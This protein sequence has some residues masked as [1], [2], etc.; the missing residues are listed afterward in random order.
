MMITR[1]RV[2][3]LISVEPEDVDAMV[4][5]RRMPRPVQVGGY[6]RWNVQQ[7]EHWIDLGCPLMSEVDCM[8]GAPSGV[9]CLVPAVSTLPDHA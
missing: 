6:E 7:L 3:A 9:E 8:V 5:A 1:E 2:A 4:A